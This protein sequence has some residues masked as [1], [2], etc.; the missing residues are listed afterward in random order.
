MKCIVGQI[1]KLSHFRRPLRLIRCICL[2]SLTTLKS[3]AGVVKHITLRIKYCIIDISFGKSQHNR[4]LNLAKFIGNVSSKDIK[5]IFFFNILFIAL[6]ISQVANLSIL[7]SS[8]WM[9]FLLTVDDFTFFAD[10]LVLLTAGWYHYRSADHHCPWC[11]AILPTPVLQLH[12]AAKYKD[13]HLCYF[14]S[15]T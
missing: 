4:V 8:S 14:I 5:L 13:Y 11:S 2:P 7:I 9:D 15:G 12:Q 6:Q 1:P 10:W 3:I